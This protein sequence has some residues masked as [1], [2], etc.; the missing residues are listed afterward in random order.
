M[1]CFSCLCL[2]AILGSVLDGRGQSADA[3]IDVFFD[4]SSVPVE[5][6]AATGSRPASEVAFRVSPR[7]PRIRYRLAGLEEQWHTQTDSAHFTVRFIDRDGRH[8]V[9]KNFAAIGESDGWNGSIEGA[10][11]TPRRAIVIAPPDAEFF[12]IVLSSAGAPT[13][14]GAYAVKG[15]SV[16][17]VSDGDGEGAFAM[18]DSRVPGSSSSVWKKSGIQPGLAS[19]L[20]L[21]D[22][23]GRSPVLCI[24]DDD[25]TGHADWA[26][27]PIAVPGRHLEV[28]W[29]EAYSIGGSGAFLVSYPRL[30]PGSYRFVVE[31]LSVLGRPMGATSAVSV[32]IPRP[33]WQLWWFWPLAIG[34]S[35]L[36]IGLWISH[37]VRK[38]INRHLRHAQLIADERLRIARD[39]HDGLGTRLSHISLIGAHAEGRVTDKQAR[40]MFREI[41]NLSGEL[42]RA[43]SETVWMLNSNNDDLEALVDFL[44]RLASDLCGL[45]GIRC[46]IDALAV[47]EGQ[48]ISHDFRHHISLSVKEL[49]NNALKHSQ[50]SEV[51]LR[52]WMERSVLHIAVSDD[53]VGLPEGCRTRGN[54]L[55]SVAHRMHAIRG[56]CCFEALEPSGLRVLLT[57]PVK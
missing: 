22:Q 36:V 8:I 40:A 10:R 7:S 42:V 20:H 54:G 13:A 35:G 9:H 25:I 32:T 55:E 16:A 1:R 41:A 28:R 49:L 24:I 57:A 53:G 44:C 33:Y 43:L 31:N 30:P 29:D 51:K 23:A 52:I 56:S 27:A 15:I 12:S 39:L 45:V 14:V 38:R 2:L 46:R 5:N 6:G 21:D 18:I 11:F 19:A 4:Q 26:T 3:V 50:A 34:C 37:L 48:A 47:K 17:S